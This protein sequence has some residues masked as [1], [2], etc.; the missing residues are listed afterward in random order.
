M[1]VWVG[2]AEDVLDGVGDG[3]GGRA[4]RYRME[5]G[6]SVDTDMQFAAAMSSG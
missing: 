4:G 1:E 3:V 2:G 6:T 5:P